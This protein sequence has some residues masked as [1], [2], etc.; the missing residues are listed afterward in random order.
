MGTQLKLHSP[1]GTVHV[2]PAAFACHPKARFVGIAYG[3][4]FE[5]GFAFGLLGSQSYTDFV[6]GI[7]QGS[8]ADPAAKN[9]LQQFG[10]L[11]VR[12]AMLVVHQGPDG[13]DATA[14]LR[15]VD[16][17]GGERSPVFY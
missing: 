11:L 7:D 12:H 2:A 8:G 1:V 16:H 9:G 10:S 3:S 4:G 15:G 13:L 17:T 5:L 14:V 6:R